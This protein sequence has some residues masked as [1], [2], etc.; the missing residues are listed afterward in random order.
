MGHPSVGPLRRKLQEGPRTF[1]GQRCR[2]RRA[3]G[4]RLLR[5]A[6]RRVPVGAQRQIDQ[7]PCSVQGCRRARPGGHAQARM[8]RRPRGVAVDCWGRTRHAQQS[9][10]RRGCCPQLPE[11]HAC[12]LRGRLCGRA[13]GVGRVRQSAAGGRRCRRDPAARARRCGRGSPGRA[14]A[15]RRAS[16]VSRGGCRRWCGCRLRRPRRPRR[17]T[18][19]RHRRHNLLPLPRDLGPRTHTTQGRALSQPGAPG[20]QREVRGAGSRQS[21]GAFR[22]KA[23]RFRGAG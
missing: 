20:R 10:A 6:H 11:R 22:Q 15:A 7:A 4:N 18:A 12:A 5:Q 23:F 17:D 16:A 8:G 9:R 2:I 21:Q 14:R 19:R 13:L 1:A 3:G